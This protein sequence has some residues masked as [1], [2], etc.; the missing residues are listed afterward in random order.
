MTGRAPLGLVVNPVAGVGGPAGLKGSDGEAAQDA[1]RAAGV[2]P[3]AGER[4]ARALAVLADGGTTDVL[5]GPGALGE[6]A[7]RAAGLVPRVVDVPLTGTGADTTALV[8]RL[9]DAG[10][11]LVLFAGGDGTARDV[12]AGL[13]GPWSDAGRPGGTAAD[14]ARVPVLGVP[15]GVKMYSACFGVSPEAAGQVAR[16][17]LDGAGA[18]PGGDVT[19][20]D[21]EVLDV[22]EDQV[23]TGRVEPRL[24]ALVPVPVQAGRSQARKAATAASEAGAVDG[25][26]AA[27]A[28]ALEPGTTY[29]VGPGGTTAALLRRVGVAGTPLGVDVVRDGALVAADVD[30]AGALA[31]V[32]AAPGPARAVVGIIGG[33]GFVLGRGNQQLSAR[34]LAAIGETL[35]PGTAPLLVAATPGKLVDLGGRP[36]LVDT[37]DPAL[38]TRLAGPTRVVTGPGTISMY[39]AIAAI[40]A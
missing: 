34:V 11:G 33:Q 16:A 14:R 37:G 30:E 31:A 12:A 9:V 39:T 8:R 22:D 3:R 26:A 29:L 7:A 13:P 24:H 36:L 28:A 5:T 38:D 40:G 10:A 18:S 6:D 21:V 20:R 35:P 2:R 17:W 23:R 15:A 19:V 27:L 32:R 25:V 4:A 1:A